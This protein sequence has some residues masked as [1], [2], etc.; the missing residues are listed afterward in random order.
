MKTDSINW[1][2]VRAIGV[3]QGA[4]RHAVTKWK[5][6]NMVP[7]KWRAH[8]VAATNGRIRWDHFEDMDKARDAS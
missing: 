4:T 8:L 2:L 1:E 3:T 6:R 7:H 5:Q